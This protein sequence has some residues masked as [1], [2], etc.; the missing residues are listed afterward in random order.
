MRKILFFALSFA[1]FMSCKK[2]AGDN[3]CPLTS[4]NFAATYRVTAVKY[5]QTPSSPEQDYYSV[6]YSDPCETDNAFVIHSNGTYN[7]EDRGTVC[8]PPDNY[9]GT[10]TLNSNTLSFDGGSATNQDFNCSGFK[11]VSNNVFTAG[12]IF[13][14]TWTKQ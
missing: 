1:S 11:L 3:G 7:Y 9:S 12:D 13:T 10:W 14:A 8:F 4:A 6:I 2:G 5:K